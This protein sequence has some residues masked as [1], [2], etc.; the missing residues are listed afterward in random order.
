MLE[1]LLV[2]LVPYGKEYLERES[3][4]VNSDAWF[5]AS[6]GDRPIVTKAQ[7]KRHAEE[8]A[9]RIERGRPYRVTFGIQAKDGKPLGD[10]ALNWILPHSRISMLGAAIGDPDYWGGG[11]GTD[12]LLLLA[13]YA[14]EWMDMRKLWL[15]TMS[16]NARVLRQMEKVGFTL[17]ARQRESYWAD[18]VLAD[19]M[20]YGM[21]REE[22]PGR[23]AMIERLGLKARKEG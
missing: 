22:W 9:E 11:Y 2:D 21:L 19:A 4:W 13:D 12:A 16:P 1:G 23:L 10:M 5:W 17:E 14:F 3:E 18:G 6:V 20:I 8:R 15:T 7:V